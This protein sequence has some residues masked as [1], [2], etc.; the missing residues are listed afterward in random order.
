MM[1]AVVHQPERRRTGNRGM[2]CR[3]LMRSLASRRALL[4][5]AATVLLFVTIKMAV[6]HLVRSWPPVQ[7]ILTSGRADAVTLG[8]L[9]ALVVGGCRAMDA[10]IQQRRNAVEAQRRQ[11][12]VLA[13]EN[14]AVVRVCQTLILEFAQ[15]LSGILGYSELLIM[16]AEAASA[17]Q[18]RELDGLHEGALRL[19]RLLETVRAVVRAAPAAGPDH[20]MADEIVRAVTQIRHRQFERTSA[21]QV[22]HRPSPEE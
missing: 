9:V 19:E 21:P 2:Q 12:E 17:A 4:S 1:D 13:A 18:R 3:T 22:P 14:A 20:H 8:V 7:M 15:P 6:H 5:A 16:S 10:P 11:R